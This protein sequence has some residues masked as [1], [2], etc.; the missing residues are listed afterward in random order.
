M[1]EGS[2]QSAPSE[3]SVLRPQNP[4]T[5]G[6]TFQPLGKSWVHLA[7]TRQRARSHGRNHAPPNWWR[8]RNLSLCLATFFFHF[9]DV[10]HLQVVVPPPS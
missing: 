8:N 3:N 5:A 10:A 1:A 4:S 9:N 6:A 2:N 7:W